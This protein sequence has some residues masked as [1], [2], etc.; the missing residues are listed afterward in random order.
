MNLTIFVITAIILLSFCCELIDSSFGMGYGTILTPSLMFFFGFEPIQIVPAIL[1]SEMASGLFGGLLHWK[2]GNIVFFTNKSESKN[3][4]LAIEKDWR[5]TITLLPQSVKIVLIITTCSIIGVLCSSF[6][7]IQVSSFA[8]KIYIGLLVS[9]MGIIMLINNNK[10]N[11]LTYSK[12]VVVGVIAAFNKSIS[13]GGYGPL[14]AG[15]QIL[16]GVGVKKAIAITAI[17]EG[18]TCALG[19]C[20]YALKT[21]IDLSLVPWFLIGSIASV[22]LSVRIVKNINT[23]QHR[24]FIA[25]IALLL[26]CLTILKLFI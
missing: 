18:L 23:K 14:I 19:I 25:I 1:F 3:Y 2:Q 12:I 5:K 7:V 6:L 13:G 20:M 21:K 24:S 26:G 16:S 22:P 9:A 17:C 15:G 10:K 11:K 8:V 4:V